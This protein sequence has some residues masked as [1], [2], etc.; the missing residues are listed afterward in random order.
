MYCTYYIDT[1]YYPV[2]RHQHI[3]LTSHGL[4]PLGSNRAASESLS[5]TAISFS[6]FLFFT[7]RKTSLL[8]PCDSP[9]PP[10]IS[11]HQNHPSINQLSSSS[12][13]SSSSPDPFR[14]RS[15][16]KLPRRIYSA[17]P[18]AHS[19]AH[20]APPTATHQPKSFSYFFSLRATHHPPSFLLIP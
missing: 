14:V 20:L 16:S 18:P 12:S 9:L 7:P 2:L 13:Q 1:H 4:L 19:T 3:P 15:N 10:S 17:H 5:V 6:F 11:L 8:S